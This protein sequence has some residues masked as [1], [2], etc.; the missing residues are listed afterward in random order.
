MHESL[1]DPEPWRKRAEELR[2]V[3]EGMKNPATRLTL[4]RLADDY[5]LLAQRSEARR[6]ARAR[7]KGAV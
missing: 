5:D 4:L 3:A 1:Y 7:I 2:A 6:D